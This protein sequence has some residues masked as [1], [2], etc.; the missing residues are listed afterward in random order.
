VMRR[1]KHRDLPQR[2]FEVGDVM[3][4]CKRAKHIAAAAITSRASFT[5]VKSLV[6]GIM[7]DL[8]V[9]YE[10]APSS[11]GCFIDGRGAEVLVDGRNI[12]SFGELH[13]AVITAFELGHPIT[14]FEMDLDALTEGKLE[15]IA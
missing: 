6:E 15:R 1:N 13:P 11:L 7:R 14:V 12:G 10:I 8:S 5:E 9:R 2:L 3:V 4:G